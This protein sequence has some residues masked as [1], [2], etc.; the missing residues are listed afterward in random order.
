[1]TN[2]FGC[3]EAQRC[4]DEQLVGA[5][6]EAEEEALGVHLAVCDECDQREQLWA[7]LQQAMREEPLPALDP[8]VERRMLSGVEPASRLVNKRRTPAWGWAAGFA[9]AAGIAGLALLLGPKLLDRLTTPDESAGTPLVDAVDSN[10][11]AVEL[12]PAATDDGPAVAQV[13]DGRRVLPGATQ[14]TAL[15][16]ESDA[17]VY[18]DRNDEQVAHFD[19]TEGL[20]VA[21]VGENREG[22]R[23][24]VQTPQVQ[25]VAH[26]TIF[27]VE[28]TERGE[29][30]YRV[31][32]GVVEVVSLQQGRAGLELAEGMEF[33][34]GEQA[35]VIAS[36]PGLERDRALLPSR[37]ELADADVATAPAETEAELLA[38]VDPSTIVAAPPSIESLT[39]LAQEHRVARQY[40][41]AC[42]AYQQLI[43]THPDSAAAHNGQVALGQ[44]KLDAM[45][46]PQDSLG[47][48]DAYLSE[49]PA[50]TL[51]AEARVGRVR[52][53]ARLGRHDDLIRAAG[54]FVQAHPDGS[55]CPEV[56]RLR[57]DARRAQADCGRARV[58]Y[59]ELIERWPDSPQADHAKA[60][61]AACDGVDPS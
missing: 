7:G 18:V 24:L 36:M 50:G 41:D 9:L 49:S 3:K 53:L 27:S 43:Q 26:G 56:I 19:L 33:H 58:D 30:I 10:P 14:G 21:E 2:R 59:E 35:A 55:A 47:H 12:A 25:V 44:M 51:A 39:R 42:A 61:I 32:E 57:A 13:I 8:L 52:A 5:L 60:G 28:I 15:W 6:S 38:R 17:V 23:F 54:E 34:S 45:D 1:M 40:D 4:L 29:E 11:A 20:V 16:L 46:R 48:F 22:F 31:T 37:T